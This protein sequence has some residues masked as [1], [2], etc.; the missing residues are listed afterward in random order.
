MSSFCITIRAQLNT[1]FQTHDPMISII[2]S[3][4][5][6]NIKA[7]LLRRRS[8]YSY[9]Q[10]NLL[11]YCKVT[12]RVARRETKHDTSAHATISNAFASSIK[13]ALMDGHSNKNSRMKRRNRLFPAK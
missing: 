2:D 12:V 4:L 8:L 1:T 5:N 7:L 13:Q 9:D 11:S 10:R 3:T 6:T